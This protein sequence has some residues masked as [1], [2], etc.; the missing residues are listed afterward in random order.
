MR[1]LHLTLKKKWFDMILS[2]E[3]TEE[4]RD[5]KEYWLRRL[6]VWGGTPSMMCPKN[7]GANS[8]TS[9][10]QCVS[11]DGMKIRTFAAIEFRNGYSANAPTMLVECKGITTGIGKPEWGAP[12]YSVFI[13]KLGEIIKTE[14]V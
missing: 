5:P 8:K 13:I 12:E 3:K 9:C 2:G 4:Y 14:N 7:W 6:C 10:W 11:E 1:V